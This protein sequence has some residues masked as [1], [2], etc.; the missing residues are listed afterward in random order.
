M[1]SIILSM[2]QSFRSNPNTCPDIHV[3]HHLLRAYTSISDLKYAQKALETVNCMESKKKRET[4]N[5]GK[6]LLSMIKADSVSPSD[7][8]AEGCFPTITSYNHAL[9]AFM[10]SARYAKSDK[11][12]LRALETIEQVISK[13]VRRRSI[14][15]A[16]PN[17]SQGVVTDETSSPSNG[18]STETYALALLIMKDMSTKNVPDLCQRAEDIMKKMM[19]TDA[20]HKHIRDGESLAQRIDSKV[21]HFL[22]EIYSAS[23]DP[24]Y[25][26]IAKSLLIAIEEANSS[27][28]HD[29]K[30]DEKPNYLNVRKYNKFI[31]KIHD[32]V[33]S[34]VKSMKGNESNVLFIAPQDAEMMS[35]VL[36]ECNYATGL[37]ESMISNGVIPDKHTFH[38]VMRTWFASGLKEAGVRSSTILSQMKALSTFLPD[39][40]PDSKSYEIAL[41]C[42]VIS[43]ATSE[44]NAASQTLLLLDRMES[45]MKDEGSYPIEHHFELAIQACSTSNLGDDKENAMAIA[46][47]IYNRMM[48]RD[49]IPSSYAFQRLLWCTTFFDTPDH[50]KTMQLSETVFNAA[51]ANDRVNESVLSM[52][53]KVN[54]LLHERFTNRN[55]NE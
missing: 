27:N 11:T 13:L 21:L 37:L 40:E 42:W 17:V 16:H 32:N 51:T 9:T 54:P 20:Y 18:P 10:H 2:N 22:F 8:V 45:M 36:N 31:K 3:Y 39:I 25:L 26:L 44:K 34:K 1:E 6:D 43:A 52:L 38:T 14:S 47:D 23:D 48:D 53:R 29:K 4:N 5:K 55:R 7:L 49:M 50:T 24:S 28:K 33:Q 15:Q 46:F 41:K 19:G 30:A 35:I 12:K